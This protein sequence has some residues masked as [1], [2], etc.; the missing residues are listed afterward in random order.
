MGLPDSLFSKDRALEAQLNPIESPWNPEWLPLFCPLKA[1]CPYECRS[2]ADNCIAPSL[3]LPTCQMGISVPA[4]GLWEEWMSSYLQTLPRGA[5]AASAGQCGKQ[6]TLGWWVLPTVCPAVRDKPTSPR[7]P[8]TPGVHT[9]GLVS[10][11]PR[12]SPSAP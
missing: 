11:V 1:L 8:R 9:P 4:T 10:Q 7:P 12:T 5:R 6:Q 2:R 3:S